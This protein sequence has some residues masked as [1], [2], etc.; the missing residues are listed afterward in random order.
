MLQRIQSLFLLLCAGAYGSLMA[1]PFASSDIPNDQMMS[2]RIFNVQDHLVLLALTIA[3]LV[4]ALVNIF[5]YSNRKR[6]ILLNYL[7]VIIAI[8]I[9][10]A[11]ALFWTQQGDSWMEQA[12]VKGQAGAFVPVGAIIL[13]LL[14]NHFIKK[15]EKTIRSSYDRLR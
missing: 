9:A 1:L 5:L 2:D 11:A 6:Q 14:A 13:A 8:L 10:G 7:L 12:V 3:G 4:L 15:D